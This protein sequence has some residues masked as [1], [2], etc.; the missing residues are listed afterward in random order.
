MI[1]LHSHIL[2]GIDD[3]V[4]TIDEACELARAAVADGILV[5]AA[6]PHV[7][8]DYPTTPDQM[9]AG[10]CAVRAALAANDIPL[11]LLPGGEIALEML[12]DLPDGHLRRF[13]LG[14]NPRCLLLETPY[15]G[16]PP[17]IAQIVF[18]LQVR[19]FRIVL[20]HPERNAEVQARPDLVQPLVDAGVLV[21]I[22]AGSLDGRLGASAQRT[23]VRLIDA[24]CAH[25]V[26]SDA[27]APSVRRVGM[28]DA[29]EAIGDQALAGWLSER[30]PE[31]ILA[32]SQVPARPLRAGRDWRFWRRGR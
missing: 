20:A 32:D 3:G 25:L 31:A 1:D 14:G 27:H 24:Q 23:A 17:G 21:Q 26:A 8:T 2:P 16:W 11:E 12:P 18:R 29:T 30:V 13:G 28:T 9:E 22:T 4:A 6:T 15:G 5:M 19:G 10:V 7:R